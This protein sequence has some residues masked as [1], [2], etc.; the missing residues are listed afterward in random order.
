MPRTTRLVVPALV[1]AALAGCGQHGGGGEPPAGEAYDAHGWAVWRA[2]AAPVYEDSFNHVASDPSVVR[3]GAG[4]RM[5]YT[6]TD[7]RH[8]D[9]PRASLCIATS[10]D[11]FAWTPVAT[12]DGNTS[13]MVGEVLRGRE[14][15][16][17]ENLEGAFLQR[18]ANDWLLYY[19]GYTDVPLPG[20]PAKGFPAALSVARSTDGLTFTRLSDA[21]LLSPTV[22]GYDDDAVYC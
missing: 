4:Y 15:S 7:F 17:E 6:G 8:P 2:R 16:W 19:S 20:A 13:G 5:A 18:R 14:G 12:T 22:G 11:G 9:G 3:D 1:I 10:P 21:P